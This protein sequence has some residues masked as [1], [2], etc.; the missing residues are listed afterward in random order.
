MKITITLSTGKVT[1]KAR[2]IKRTIDY[3]VTGHSLLI[4]LAS[5]NAIVK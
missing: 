4:Q 1:G 3:S 5:F 2:E